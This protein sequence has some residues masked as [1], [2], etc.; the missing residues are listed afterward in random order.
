ML[1]PDDTN[2]A[3]GTS[4][5]VFRVKK[6]G[7]QR[8][9][10]MK[11]ISKEVLV[12]QRKV[13]H[14]LGKRNML[15]RTAVSDLPFIISLK[16]SFQTREDLYLITEYMAGG[17]LRQQLRRHGR[18]TQECAKF[19]IA[20]VILALQHLH[21]NNIVFGDLRPEKILLDEDGH[22]ALYNFGQSELGSNLQKNRFEELNEY[23][24]PEFLGEEVS[25]TKMVDF[26]SLG[27]L[28]YEMICG[29]NPFYADDNEQMRK[30]ITFGKLRFPKHVI[31]DDE[32]KFIQG[33]VKRDPLSRLGSSTGAEEIKGH[34]FLADCDWVSLSLKKIDP[35]LKPT[36]FSEQFPKQFPDQ[37][38]DQ[39]P[40]QFPKQLPKISKI[41]ELKERAA[42]AFSTGSTAGWSMPLSPGMQANFKGFTYVDETNMDQHF[43]G[44]R[45]TSRE[46]W[47]YK[48]SFTD[49]IEEETF[50]IDKLNDDD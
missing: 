33:L 19:Y 38:P 15:V 50:K 30:R 4:G 24:A 13:A 48:F 41:S 3:T 34:P 18:F 39:F 31:N 17:E 43:R 47:N 28:F 5:Q 2:M 42:A 49:G 27:V 37:F 35:P 20:E 11:V 22:I 12:K 36:P 16:F 45:D 32:K 40:K 9:Y 23:T 21:Q 1:K 46:Y 7:S 25:Y 8:I 6:K 10:A 14:I 26:W 29:W 44:E